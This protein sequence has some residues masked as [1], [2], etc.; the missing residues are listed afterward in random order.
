VLMPNQYN[1][2]LHDTSSP[3]YFRASDRMVSSGCVRVKEP[4]KLADFILT[5]KPGWTETSTDDLLAD[6]KMKDIFL[7]Q[8]LPV[9]LLYLTVW[10]N[11][12]GQL[13]YGPDI[14]DWDKMMIAELAKEKKLPHFSVRK[15]GTALAERR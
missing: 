10:I 1:I 13:T 5:S 2:Y 14:Y 7:P 11:E 3:E 12:S 4:E 8:T 6:G 9:Y 15:T